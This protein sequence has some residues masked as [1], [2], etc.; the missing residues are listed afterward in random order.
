MVVILKT[1]DQNY[2]HKGMYLI[3]AMSFFQVSG[4]NHNSTLK[5]AKQ[6]VC[7]LIQNRFV[8]AMFV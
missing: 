1:K 3:L 2:L 4:T 5:N 6:S 7:D 8:K